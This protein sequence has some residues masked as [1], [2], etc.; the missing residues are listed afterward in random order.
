MKVWESLG[1]KVIVSRQNGSLVNY[2]VHFF[3]CSYAWWVD[4]RPF[5]GKNLH[6]ATSYL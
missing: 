1:D 6:Y 3:V 4:E 2:I 5:V